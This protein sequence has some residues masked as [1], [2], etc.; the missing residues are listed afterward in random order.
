MA[1]LTLNHA[2]S[3][4]PSLTLINAEQTHRKVFNNMECFTNQ[5]TLKASSS[6]LKVT[7]AINL[8][9]PGTYKLWL[10]NTIFSQDDGLHCKT[11]SMKYFLFISAGKSAVQPA[12]LF[13]FIICCFTGK[14]KLQGTF[15][16]RLTPHEGI[17]AVSSRGDWDS[18]CI[19]GTCCYPSGRMSLRAH[20][21]DVLLQKRLKEVALLWR[22]IWLWFFLW[23]FG[24]RSDYLKGGDY[25]GAEE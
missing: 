14:S 19:Q 20:S 16:P 24:I 7:A 1:F 13:A 21:Q 9:L 12:S 4:L 22:W 25:A 3:M 2:F 23:S 18:S 10:H 5:V 8:L 6:R 11:S 17:K 15:I